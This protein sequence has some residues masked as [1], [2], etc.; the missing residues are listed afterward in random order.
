MNQRSGYPGSTDS[1]HGE[2]CTRPPA[3]P[4]LKWI[5]AT[6][7][8]PGGGRSAMCGPLGLAKV[9]WRSCRGA[10]LRRNVELGCRSIT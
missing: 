2:S 4:A 8:R 9:N 7:S 5:D 3:S 10:A 1:N 6:I